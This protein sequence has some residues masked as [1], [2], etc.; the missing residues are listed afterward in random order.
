MLRK[1]ESIWGRMLKSLLEFVNTLEIEEF[2][3]AT[4]K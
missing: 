4:E 3:M 2:H 1:F